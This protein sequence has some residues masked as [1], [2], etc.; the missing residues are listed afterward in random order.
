MGNQNVGQIKRIDFIELYVPTWILKCKP[1]HI[2]VN[3]SINV[4]V[5]VNQSVT[6]NFFLD[7]HRFGQDPKMVEYT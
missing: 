2:T 6:M 1:F 7:L 4:N 3:W 5:N